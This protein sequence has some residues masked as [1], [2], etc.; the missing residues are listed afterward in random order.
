[1]RVEVEIS[2][3]ILDRAHARRS[4]NASKRIFPGVQEELKDGFDRMTGQ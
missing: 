4:M 3:D 2:S 1:M